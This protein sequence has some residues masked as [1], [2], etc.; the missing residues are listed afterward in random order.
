MKYCRFAKSILYVIFFS[1]LVATGVR[2]HEGH[3][4]APG[5]SDEAPVS[6]PIAIGAEAKENLGLTT[7]PV[8]VRT[9]ENILT[10]IGQTVAIPNRIAAVSSRI[11]GRVTELMV[12]EGEPV[13]K[14]QI[15]VDFVPLQEES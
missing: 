8:E 7:V 15:L 6:G 3:S 11:S 5:E 12:T 9:L 2:A 1:S 4:E 13:E 10:V 14:G